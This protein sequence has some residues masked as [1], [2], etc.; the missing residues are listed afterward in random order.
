MSPVVSFNVV[1]FSGVAFGNTVTG[2]VTV[3]VPF[4]YVTVVVAVT[5]VAPALPVVSGNP[6]S[7]GALA[8]PP[9][10][11][12]TAFLTFSASGF[13][14]STVYTGFVSEPNTLIVTGTVV[15][16]VVPST[17]YVASTFTIPLFVPFSAVIVANTSSVISPTVT[18]APVG[19]FPLKSA[20]STNAAALALATSLTLSTLSPFGTSTSPDAF[21]NTVTGTLTVSV[22][23]PLS[24][25]TGTSTLTSVAP[26]LPAVSG[27]VVGSPFVPSVPG[28]TAAFA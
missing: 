6:V 26:A 24:Y 10:P 13:V 28:V 5:S 14:P 27:N 19:N 20:A 23:L 4:G 7:V 11:G 2:T 17:V 16:Y 25:V 9:L 3:S 18:V 15:L 21:G 22:N 12:V 8:V 1:T